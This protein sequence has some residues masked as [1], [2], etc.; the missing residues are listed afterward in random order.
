MLWYTYNSVGENGGSTRS[1]YNKTND[2]DDDDCYKTGFVEHM[3]AT[4][5]G[6]GIYIFFI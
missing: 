6:R 3:N 2:D 1:I 4:W 5:G